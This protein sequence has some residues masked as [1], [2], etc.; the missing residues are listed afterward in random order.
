[1]KIEVFGPGCHKCQETEKIVREVVAVLGVE[2][3]VEKISDIMKIA[4]A[5]I[6][7]A[8]AVKINGKVKC[9]GRVPKLDEVK[10]WIMEEKI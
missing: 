2:A 7:L 10:A 8:P 1:M 4:Q 5:G 3:S 9:T 6:M